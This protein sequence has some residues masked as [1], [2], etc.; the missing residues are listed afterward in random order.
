MH[1]SLKNQ[2]A[3]V[4]QIV[5]C[6]QI[7]RKIFHTTIVRF[8]N[9]MSYQNSFRNYLLKYDTTISKHVIEIESISR[10]FIHQFHYSINVIVYGGIM[11]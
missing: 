6:K 5:M 7:I 2:E 8:S 9:K 1:F 10:F 3:Q 4:L 11:I